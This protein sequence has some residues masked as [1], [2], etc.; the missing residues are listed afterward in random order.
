MEKIKREIQIRYPDDNRLHSIIVYQVDRTSDGRIVISYY[1]ITDGN[2]D[3]YSE[4][5]N[6]NGEWMKNPEH[7]DWNAYEFIEFDPLFN[8]SVINSLPDKIEISKPKLEVLKETM[9]QVIALEEKFVIE[10]PKHRLISLQM[11][12]FANEGEDIINLRPTKYENG[13]LTEQEYSF[14]AC[15]SFFRNGQITDDDSSLTLEFR[16]INIDENDKKE[17]YEHIKLF[18]AR[19]GK[20]SISDNNYLQIETKSNKKY[21]IDW[22][23][24]N[25]WNLFLNTQSA[26]QLLVD[27]SSV[28]NVTFPDE[29]SS[30]LH[31][32]LP[33]KMLIDG[34]Y[35]SNGIEENPNIKD[36]IKR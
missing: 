7:L 18:I 3:S 19:G 13:N 15:T 6:N 24:C 29:L 14:E 22:S 34:N 11:I 33:L 23:S 27:V 2:I 26:S 31:Y 8:N 10:P 32:E 1:D 35:Y 16:R 21:T 9:P 4:I 25:S 28:S 30:A 5:V 36:K 12:S 20:V 17:I